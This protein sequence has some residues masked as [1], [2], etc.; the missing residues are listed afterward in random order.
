MLVH[1]AFKRPV[2]APRLRLHATDLHRARCNAPRPAQATTMH[3]LACRQPGAPSTLCR[4]PR[5]CTRVADEL[6]RSL[7]FTAPTC[8]DD[9]AFPRLHLVVCRNLL[10]YLR[11]AASPRAGQLL[12]LRCDG[13][14]SSW[15]QRVAR[16][17]DAVFECLDGRAPAPQ[18]AGHA[19][20]ARTC[21]RSFVVAACLQR[22]AAGLQDAK[23][24]LR[25]YELMP[26]LWPVASW[27]TRAK[28]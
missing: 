1:E 14:R 4:S 27:S 12:H 20:A 13:V 21:G 6:R 18:T 26:S 25:L 10:I 15:A 24:Q 3:C 17:D 2:L 22:T 19:A 9:A 5:A 23:A 16:Q 28:S 7:V 11:P 8:C